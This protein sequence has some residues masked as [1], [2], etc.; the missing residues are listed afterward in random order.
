MS[1]IEQ[2][3]ESHDGEVPTHRD[4][5]LAES[6]QGTESGDVVVADRRCGARL[7]F[8]QVLQRVV[9]TLP[10]GQGGTEKLR[11]FLSPCRLRASV[12]A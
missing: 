1:G 10:G 6:C 12:A 4:A 8:E 2:A 9:S 5:A 3:V 11:V 7:D